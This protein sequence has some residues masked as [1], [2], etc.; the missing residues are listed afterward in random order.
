[1]RE[2]CGRISK[3]DDIIRMYEVLLGEIVA[4]SLQLWAAITDTHA[5]SLQLCAAVTV[6]EQRIYDHRM[7][8]D[9]RTRTYE[10]VHTR[11]YVRGCTR[12]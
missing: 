6:E 9:V 5:R 3:S 11:T 2:T 7:Y 1:M 10:D 12:I 4:R 8:E